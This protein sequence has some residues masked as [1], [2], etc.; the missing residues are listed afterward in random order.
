MRT[1][2]ELPDDL[3][4]RVRVQVE[5]SGVTMRTLI[6]EALEMRL[7][8]PNKVRRPPPVVGKA[9]VAPMGALTRE[10][11]DEASL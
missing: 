8:L 9:D 5:T 2:V 11:I 6:I 3:M 1:T 10:Q 7:A 4:G